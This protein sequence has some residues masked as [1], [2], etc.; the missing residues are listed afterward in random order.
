MM[1]HA[2][3]SHMRALH[4]DRCALRIVQYP[5]LHGPHIGMQTYDNVF[6]QDVMIASNVFVQQDVAHMFY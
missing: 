3:V 2:G 5:C 6:W 4:Q 1:F